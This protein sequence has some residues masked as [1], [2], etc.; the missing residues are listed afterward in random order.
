MV[1][2]DADALVTLLVNLLDN[3]WK[4]SGEEKEIELSAEQVSADAVE[5]RVRDNG[6]G[7]AKRHQGRIFQRFY[8][9]DR[10]LSRAS[11]GCGLGLAIVQFIAKAHHAEVSVASQPGRGSTFC[12]RLAAFL[13]GSHALSR[14]KVWLKYRIA[15]QPRPSRQQ[16][17][18]PKTALSHVL[19]PCQKQS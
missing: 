12:V 13:T 14:R 4:Y 6:I 18:P 10:Q 17:V 8:Q 9:V 1:Q 7:I 3:A 15:L 2:G 11:G 5:I 16:G 19:R